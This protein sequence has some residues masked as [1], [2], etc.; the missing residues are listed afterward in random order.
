MTLAAAR[1]PEFLP[2]LAQAIARAVATALQAKGRKRKMLAVQVGAFANP[3]G[4]EQLLRRLEVA[5][6]KG[7]IV[8]KEI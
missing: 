8:Q 2:A 3:W 5:G 6:F 4:A 7:C 1:R